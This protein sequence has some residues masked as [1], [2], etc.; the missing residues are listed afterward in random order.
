MDKL[1]AFLLL[2]VTA[3][4]FGCDSS[5]HAYSAL[6]GAGYTDI[7]ITGYTIFGC[8]EDDVFHT[9]FTAKGPTGVRVSGVVCSGWI[10]GTTIRTN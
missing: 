2:A 6:K 3:L 4:I 1:I 10:K 9:G 8:S 7:H 5:D